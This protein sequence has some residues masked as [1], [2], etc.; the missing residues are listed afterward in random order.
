MRRERTDRGRWPDCSIA[1]AAIF[2]LALPLTAS[3][4]TYP[5]AVE[6]TA[7]VAHFWP[8]GEASGSTFADVVGGA[9]AEASGGVTLGE[10]GGLA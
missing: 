9:N 1:V 4:E 3:A 6:G 10:P 8:M 2:L 7:G 5:E